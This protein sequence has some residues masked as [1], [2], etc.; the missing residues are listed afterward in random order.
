MPFADSTRHEPAMNALWEPKILIEDST[1]GVLRENFYVCGKHLDACENTSLDLSVDLYPDDTT[2]FLGDYERVYRLS[3][4]G[5][6]ETRQNRIVTAHRARGGLTEAYY[7]NLGNTLGDGTYTVN[8]SDGTGGIP[9]IIHTY[10]SLSSPQGP[11]TL[12]PGKLFEEA[13]GTTPWHLRVDVSGVSGP[14]Q[15]LEDMLNRL[16]PAHC[17]MTFVYT[18]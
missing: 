5:S 4:I 12:L 17:D 3:G 10:S 6:T 14:E 18:I 11:A 2:S 1:G 7:E 13:T 15:D 16:K 8:L 9:F